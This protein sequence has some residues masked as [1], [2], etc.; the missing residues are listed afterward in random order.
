VGQVGRNGFAPLFGLESYI[1]QGL[2]K[3]GHKKREKRCIPQ[4]FFQKTGGKD[5]S[6]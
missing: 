6:Y 1:L 5:G 2:K 3:V 4:K